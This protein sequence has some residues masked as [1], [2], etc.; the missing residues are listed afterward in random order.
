MYRYFACAESSRFCRP[1][2]LRKR[3]QQGGKPCFSYVT[4]KGRATSGGVKVR[5]LS[6][7]ASITKIFNTW[8]NLSRR[9]I[10]SLSFRLPN[11][12]QARSGPQPGRCESQ[13]KL[14]EMQ[15]I[16]ATIEQLKQ[17]RLSQ[18]CFYLLRSERKNIHYLVP[19]NCADA[20]SC[21]GEHCIDKR[22][23]LEERGGCPFLNTFIFKLQINL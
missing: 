23:F 6:R 11:A 20:S 4:P 1:G 14:R 3:S 22:L 15:K 5:P 10:R 18:A 2:W 17:R 8:P 16:Q 13:R 7:H 19:L 9:T 21:A 12:G